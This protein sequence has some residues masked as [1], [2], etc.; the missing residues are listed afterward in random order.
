MRQ[1]APL[2][3]VLYAQV[4]ACW[5]HLAM[6]FLDGTPLDQIAALPQA[7]RNRIGTHLYRLLFR[8]LF[9]F[10]FVQTDPNFANLLLLP[11]TEQVALLDL[12]TARTVPPRSP[13]QHKSAEPERTGH[14]SE[15]VGTGATQ[16]RCRQ[17][18]ALGAPIPRHGAH[19]PA[20]SRQVRTRRAA[21]K[22]P[23]SHVG[24]A[25]PFVL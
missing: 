2:Q 16:R 17:P 11:D 13:R 25:L 9:E 6:D 22:Q 5:Q 18:R 20:N 3:E 15:G 7:L 1:R 4:T 24:L 14:K 12:G 10:R 21:K 19:L 23:V 8:E